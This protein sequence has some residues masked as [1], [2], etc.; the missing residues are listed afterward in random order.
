M[1]AK[2][3]DESW[4]HAEEATLVEVFH[5][6]QFMKAV[7]AVRR[8]SPLRLHKKSALRCLKLNAENI[9]NYYFGF[10]FLAAG[11]KKQ[12]R[13]TNGSDAHP[14]LEYTGWRER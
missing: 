3:G 6:D 14:Q 11:C 5:P 13:Y 2:L 12:Y 9:W 4:H 10:F 8:P 7:D 1:D